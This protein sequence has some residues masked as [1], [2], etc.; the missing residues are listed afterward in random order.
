MRLLT[1]TYDSRMS[2]WDFKLLSIK[3]KSDNRPT[4]KCMLAC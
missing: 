1:T 3:S 4:H 2:G